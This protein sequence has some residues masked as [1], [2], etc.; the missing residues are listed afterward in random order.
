MTA[1]Q[2]HDTRPPAVRALNSFNDL[3]SVER[4]VMPTE[5]YEAL[6]QTVLSYKRSKQIGRFDPAAPTLVAQQA[7]AH[8]AEVAHRGIAAGKRCR[9]L[10]AETD[11]RRG[12][13]RHVG[14]VEGLPGVGPW[15]GIELD[16]PTGRNDGSGPGGKKYFSCGNKCGVFVRPERVEVGAFGAIDEFADDEDDEAMEEI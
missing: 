15:I 1:A 14:E 9:L 10:P 11:D 4:Y 12:Y 13:V 16:E 5:T 8:S 3:S 6:P 7:A 2:V